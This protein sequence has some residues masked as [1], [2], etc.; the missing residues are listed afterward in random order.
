[1][2]PTIYSSSNE[3]AKLQLT[4]ISNVYRMRIVDGL[5]SITTNLTAFIN[6]ANIVP[7]KE[8]V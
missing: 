6:V 1:M 7:Q 4:D 5:R 8:K 3:Y 2:V